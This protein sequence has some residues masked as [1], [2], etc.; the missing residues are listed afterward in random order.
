MTPR[1]HHR[2][3]RHRR[4]QRRPARGTALLLALVIVA[5]V[6]TLAAAMV[7]RQQR[8]LAVEA[9]ERARAQSA[10]VLAGALDWARLIL[11]E[12][13]RQGRVDELGEPWAVPLAEARLSTFLAAERGSSDGPEAFLSGAIH[14]LQ[15][16]LNLR[17]L[18]G[19]DGEPDALQLAALTRLCALLGLPPSLAPRIAGGLAAAQRADDPEAPL[20]PTR[21]AQLRWLGIDAATI[22]RLQP[23]VTLL[24]QRSAVNVNTAPREVLAAAVPELDL[25]GAERIVQRRARAPYRTPQEFAAELGRDLGD[26]LDTLA[27]GS[28][29]FEV[30]GRL[31][32]DGQV[33][34]ERSI[35]QRS[36][37]GNVATLLRERRSLPPNALP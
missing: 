10:W 5:L 24:P 21:L 4:L 36:G 20:P 27:T 8:A 35:V 13:A 12:D 14:D 17:N 18:V 23:F 19:Q 32:L 26:T 16:R 22:E 3:H 9:A 30:V 7:A 1:R 31:R 6:A 15:A 33:F 34:E 29:H 11:R 2:H 25:G 37:R 28:S